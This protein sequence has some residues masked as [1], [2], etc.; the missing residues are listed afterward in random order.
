MGTEDSFFLQRAFRLQNILEKFI[1][2]LSKFLK[3]LHNK[4]NL[5]SNNSWIKVTR[6]VSKQFT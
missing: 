3:H 4:L 2:Y 6:K 5:F 1:K